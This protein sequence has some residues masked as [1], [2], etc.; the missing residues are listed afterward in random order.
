MYGT[1]VINL[2]EFKPIGSYWIALYVNGNILY[3]WEWNIYNIFNIC[4]KWQYNIFW[5]FGVE[6]IPKEI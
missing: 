1:Y 3:I 4:N 5:Q 2:N 6:H